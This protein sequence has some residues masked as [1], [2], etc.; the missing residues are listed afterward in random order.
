MSAKQLDRRADFGRSVQC[1]ASAD[2][3]EPTLGFLQLVTIWLRP[4]DIIP[5]WA[6]P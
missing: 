1:G 4:G 2:G 5:I 3:V 6:A